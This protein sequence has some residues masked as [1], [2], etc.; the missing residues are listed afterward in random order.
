MNIAGEYEN[1]PSQVADWPHCCDV[2][3][4]TCDGLHG[5]RSLKSQVIALFYRSVWPGLKLLHRG[6][7]WALYGKLKPILHC[8]RKTLKLGPRVGLDPQREI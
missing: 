2:R 5:S 1:I 6:A 8:D 4:D 3:G 7:S